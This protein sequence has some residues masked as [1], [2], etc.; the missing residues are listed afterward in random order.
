LETE[1]RERERESE[2][3]REASM[4]EVVREIK[5]NLELKKY[6]REMRKVVYDSL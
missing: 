1:R 2:K 3:E 4:V 6:R 5:L